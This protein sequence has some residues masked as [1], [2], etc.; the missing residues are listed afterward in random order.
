MWW[1]VFDLVPGFVWA[2]ICAVLLLFTGVSYVRMTHAKA[3]L[4]EYRT[5][6]AENTRQAEAAARAKE[7][8]MRNQVDRIANNAAKNQTVLAA[9]VATTQLIAGQLRDDIERLNARPAPTD[10]ESAAIA[11]EARTAR[12]LLG[13]CAEE[14]RSVAQAADELRDQVTGLQDYATSVCKN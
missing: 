12:K 3:E 8:A 7:Q 1:K 14:Y 11:G 4:A 6:V 5:V 13:A 9:R 10:A 2:A